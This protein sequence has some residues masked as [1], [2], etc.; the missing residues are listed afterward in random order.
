MTF[1]IPDW[2]LRGPDI[3]AGSWQ[4]TRGICGMGGITKGQVASM[5]LHYRYFPFEYFLDSAAAN[6]LTRIELWAGAPH[7][8]IGDI[9]PADV[10]RISADLERRDLTAVCLTP[11]QCMYPINIASREK[12]LRE[13]S[14][15]YFEKCINVASDLGCPCFW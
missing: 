8:Y 3:R 14:V 2:L 5:N 15:R 12:V 10:R 4:A 1:L 11:E 9:R 6:G 13:R 7:F